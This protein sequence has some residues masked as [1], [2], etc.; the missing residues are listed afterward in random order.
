MRDSIPTLLLLGLMVVSIVASALW[1]APADR[2]LLSPAPMTAP[3]Q[4]QAGASPRPTPTPLPRNSKDRTPAPW[5]G[6]P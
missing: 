6:I 2:E 1:A 5:P 4:V 3:P